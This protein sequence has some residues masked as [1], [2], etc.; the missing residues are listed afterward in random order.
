MLLL[1]AEKIKKIYG[2]R[3]VLDVEALWVY[4]GDRIGV[5]GANGAGKT[6]L[7]QILAG[8]MEA[9]EGQ[10]QRFGEISWCRQFAASEK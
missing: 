7:F 8:E 4:A 9:E 6:T 3:I 2:E 10:V 5:V 1:R